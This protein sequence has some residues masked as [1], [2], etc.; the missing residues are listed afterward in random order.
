MASKYQLRSISLPSRS[1]PSTIRVDEEL[2]KLKTWEAT[3]TSTSKSIAIGFSL[4]QDLYLSL[5]AF[6][7]MASTQ[8]VISQ[9]QGGDEKYFEEVLD[10]SIR[11]LDICGITRDIIL[12]IKENVQS[13]HSSLRRRKGDSSVEKSVLEYNLFT[14]KM[15]KNSKKVITNLKH[16]DSNFGVSPILNL[17]DHFGA[18]VRVLREVILMN[19]FVFQLL[20]SFFNMSKSKSKSKSTKWLMVAKLLHK[21]VIACDEDNSQ[22]VNELQC[23]EASLSTLLIEGI[24]NG[25]KM[26]IAHEKLGALENVLESLDNNL[27]ST[28][29][30]LIKTRASLLNMIFHHKIW[31][32]FIMKRATMATFKHSSKYGVRSISLPTRSHPS[33]IQVEEELNKLKSWDSS[34]SSSSLSK[35]ETICYGLL[36]LGKLYKCIEDL[37]KL[38]LT[39][40]ALGQHKDEK[41]VN[42]FLDCPLRFLDLLGKTRDSI[43]LMKSS[44]EDLQ[45]SLRRRKIGNLDIE[46]H[47]SSYWSLRRNIR[48]ECTKNLLFLK[49]IDDGPFPPPPLDLDDDNHLCALVRVLRES[50]LITSSIFQSLFVFLSSS[51]LKSKPTKWAFVSRLVHKGVLISCNNNQQENVNALEKV[52]LSLCNLE[53]TI[54]ENL[55]KEEVGERIQSTNRSLEALVLG[56]QGIEEGLECL[57]K[58]L[59]NTRVSFL[60][61]ISP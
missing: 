28:F 54:M 16:M 14:K 42:E 13:L 53:L 5:D 35:V 50:S 19:L 15:K 51:I 27:D 8:H 39:Q 40:Q 59:I 55:N 3:S 37:L 34:S 23:V 44:V 2:I 61:I 56:I 9:N 41:W 11:V 10:G 22:N 46:G 47:I 30:N 58:H 48:K 57:F 20:L 25:E 24:N 36:G 1:H 26:H 32:P 33:T 45:S 49:Q 29:R 43:M 6:L 60:N 31:L 38:P 18:V 12:Q 21:G 52:D 17:G 7:N 4:L